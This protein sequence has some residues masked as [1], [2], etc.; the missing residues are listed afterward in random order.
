MV[1][2][3]RSTTSRPRRFARAAC[4]GVAATA[5][6]CVASAA[7]AA[8]TTVAS[9]RVIVPDGTSVSQL[10][11]GGETRWFAFQVEPGK[12]YVVDAIDTSGDLGANGVGTLS[13]VAADGVSA[14]PDTHVDCGAG[15]RDLAPGL[16]VT[17]N[18]K[19]CTVYVNAPDDTTLNRR[20]VYVGMTPGTGAA[21]NV[22]VR[23]STLY[24]RWT[25]NGYD[26]HLELDNTSADAICVRA[27][28][29]RDSGYTFSG[30]GW[31]DASGNLSSQDISVPANGSTKIVLA[32]G[33]PVGA[34]VRGTLRLLGCPGTGFNYVPGT[35]HVSTYAFNPVTSVYLFFYNWQGH[36]GSAGNSW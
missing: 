30:S 25:T 11:N 2:Q 23:E 5:L 21:V 9:A 36:N 29:Y 27:L 24:G 31:G 7:G 15:L 1:Q 33:T 35:V 19:R 32:S 18:G 6:A 28:F 26:F 13:I 22:R 17:D 34:S 16:N 12:M 3:Q 14:P 8:N 10:I 4:A 20:G